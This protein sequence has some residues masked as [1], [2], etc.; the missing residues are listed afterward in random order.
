MLKSH[1]DLRQCRISC[2]LSQAVDGCIDKLRAGAN[3]GDRIGCR[4]PEIV[5]GVNLDIN[6][7][8]SLPQKLH[9]VE[10]SKWVHDPERVTEAEVVTSHSSGDLHQLNQEG[11]IGTTCVLAANRY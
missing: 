10:H 5:V 8:H 9:P 6:L 2:P 11:H 3:A 7:W 4:H 1:D